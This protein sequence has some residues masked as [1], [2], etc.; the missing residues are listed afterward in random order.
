[1]PPQ[2]GRPASTWRTPS[3]VSQSSTGSW[4]WPNPV[5]ASQIGGPRRMA[6]AAT[7]RRIRGTGSPWTAA[8]SRIASSASRSEK[9]LN[10]PSVSA[11]RGSW[12]PAQP[13]LSA[14]RATAESGTRLSGPLALGYGDWPATLYTSSGWPW[15]ATIADGQKLMSRSVWVVSTNALA[16]EPAMYATTNAPTSSHQS[17]RR[18]ITANPDAGRDQRG[19]QEPVLKL[20]I[21]HILRI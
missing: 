10:T 7:R 14:S 16:A 9:T 12:L 17:Q 13:S 6:A 11:V 2:P 19:P 18:L 5:T 8:M 3:S 15:A 20:L 1:M 4:R 21:M